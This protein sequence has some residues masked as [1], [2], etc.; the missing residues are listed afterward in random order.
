MLYS[1]GSTGAAS[2]LP[3]PTGLPQFGQNRESSNICDPQ[4]VQ[5]AMSLL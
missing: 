1:S 2:A 4:L 5:N 3:V